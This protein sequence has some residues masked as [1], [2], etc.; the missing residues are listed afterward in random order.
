M[1]T[2]VLPLSIV[3]LMELLLR[4]NRVLNRVSDRCPSYTRAVRAGHPCARS[5]TAFPRS[6]AADAADADEGQDTEPEECGGGADEFRGGL[7]HEVSKRGDARFCHIDMGTPSVP[8]P[9]AS[10]VA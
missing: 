9:A 1:C 5:P 10:P 3:L 4:P 6:A 8:E 2:T 7:R